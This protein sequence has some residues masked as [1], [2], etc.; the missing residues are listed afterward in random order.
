I[1]ELVYYIEICRVGSIAQAGLSL[2]ISQPALSKAVRR[3]EEVVGARLLDRS[4][5]GVSPT[6]IGH[7]LL[8]R[9][10]ILVNDLERTRD[11]LRSMSGAQAGSVAIGVPPTLCHEFLPNV[12]QM[13][14]QH[15]P[16][17]NF[18]VNEG[19]FRHLHPQ[20]QRGELDF[21]IS[22]PDKTE[23]LAN[24]LNYERL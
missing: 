15:R 12:V 11:V 8:E 3:L 22:S 4:A 5:Q 1:P 19:L 17:L 6:A 10:H 14:L 2:G 21:I 9:A 13:A 20:L 18:R 16:G 23:T 24:D 7:T